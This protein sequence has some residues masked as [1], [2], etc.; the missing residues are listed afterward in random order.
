MEYQFK[1]GVNNIKNILFVIV[2]FL[3]GVLI[4]Q[5]KAFAPYLA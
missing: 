1:A 4:A 5:A 3:P 2:F